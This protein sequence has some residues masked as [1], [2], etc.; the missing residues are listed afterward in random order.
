MICIPAEI[1]SELNEI[2]DGVSWNDKKQTEKIYTLR[3]STWK[4]PMI[5]LEKKLPRA[6]SMTWL[7]I[8]LAFALSFVTSTNAQVWYTAL[9]GDTYDRLARS[10]DLTLSELM[11]ANINVA[12]PLT[13]GLKI[14]IPASVQ[15]VP[16]TERVL[17]R[18]DH[19]V[20][21]VGETWYGISKRYG[22]TDAELQMANG[23]MQSVL[24]IGDV[25]LVPTVAEGDSLAEHVSFESS[26]VLR[27]DT[28]R[29]LA[30]LPFMLEVD[31]V[32][33]GEY[34]ARTTRLR[35]VSLDFFHGMEWAAQLLQDSGYAVQLRVV[36]TEPDTLGIHSWSEADLN[37]SDVVLGPLRSAKMDSV[38]Q[39][40]S[41]TKTPQ[42][43]LTP[44]KPAVWS[45]H[46]RVFSLRSDERDGMRKL[47]ALVARTHPMDTVLLL[48]TRGKDAALESA[49]KEGFFDVRGSLDGLESL[50]TNNRFAEGITA[51]M[52]TSK[53]NVVAIP[54]GK[55]AQSMI[56]Y[57]QTELQLADS[58]PIRIYANSM[59][60]ELDFMERD[61]MTRASWTVPISNFIDWTDERVQRQT[62]RFRELYGSDPG[63]YSIVAFDAL[64]ECSKW[65][66]AMEQERALLAPMQYSVQWKWDDSAAQLVN[67]NWHI[68]R[69]SNGDWSR[70]IAD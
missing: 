51:S 36:D 34:D 33:G 8:C 7:T 53:L 23:H 24:G 49:F 46:N 58:F 44:L 48:E 10:N 70:L 43:L 68:R 22:I 11:E 1:P 32:V 45:H 16:P 64:V 65:M 62:L 19:H 25:L 26:P 14:W 41:Q 9:P 47:G 38:N 55:S 29:V 3:I 40:L 57:V 31:T 28:L 17:W 69:F 54:A 60:A 13:P 5:N 63:P 15:L 50:P 21:A 39:L 67:S 35:E 30:M 27:S 61:F 6:A 2:R 12:T 56:A 42:W 20:V 18:G 52:D 37:W 66:E 4:K 59:T